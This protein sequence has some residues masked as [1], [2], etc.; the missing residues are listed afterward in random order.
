MKDERLTADSTM[1]EED[2]LKSLRVVVRVT[3][4]VEAELPLGVVVLGEVE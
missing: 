4:G 1:G 2:P 3:H